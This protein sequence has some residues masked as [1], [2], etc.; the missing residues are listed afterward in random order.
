MRFLRPVLSMGCFCL[1]LLVMA[2]LRVASASSQGVE[3]APDAPQ[4]ADV[5]Q[6]TITPTVS[7]ESPSSTF[8]IALAALDYE[9]K[10][11]NSPYASTEYTLRL[12]EGWELSEES[13]FDL[14]FSYTYTF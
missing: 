2:V 3:I 1:L 8:Q 9:E 5:F 6:V 10:V 7:I 4:H 14:D 11:L 12:P 13:F